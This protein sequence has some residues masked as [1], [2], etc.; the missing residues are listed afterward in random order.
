MTSL[1]T[2]YVCERKKDRKQSTNELYQLRANRA[3]ISVVIMLYYFR[4]DSISSD[5]H[6]DFYAALIAAFLS[7]YI[8]LNQL[9]DSQLSSVQPYTLTTAKLVQTKISH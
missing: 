5:F 3:K 7:P 6:L 1:V 8:H 2:F 4:M 9:A